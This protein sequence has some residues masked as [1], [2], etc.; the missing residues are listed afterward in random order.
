MS[1]LEVSM[2]EYGVI[3]LTLNDPERRNPL[4][5]AMQYEMLR[6]LR[7]LRRQKGVRAVI[8]TGAGKAFCAGG[9]IKAFGETK[10]HA[11][12]AGMRASQELILEMEE[13]PVPVIGAINGAA[14]GAGF[15]LAM[16]CDVL[17]AAESAR[18]VPAFSAIGAVPDLGLAYTLQRSIGM[19]RTLDVLLGGKTL[20]AKSAMALGLVSEVVPD[21]E[22]NAQ[23]RACAQRI[24]MGPTIALGYAKQLI[25][26]SQGTSLGVFLRLEANAQALAFS[27][28]DFQEGVAAFVERRQARFSGA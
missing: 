16:A 12:H 9:D 21:K 22:F 17:I 18:F 3:S 27:T 2:D 8:L 14:A 25:R 24:A 13:L 11:N 4:S 19:H 20:D 23:V 10:P 6:E 26:S 1:L 5:G 15:A 28:D 7:K